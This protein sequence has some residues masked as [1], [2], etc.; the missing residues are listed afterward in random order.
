M[1]VSDVPPAPR[2]A[3]V[4]A[5]TNRPFFSVMVPSYNFTDYMQA[6]LESVL[7]QDPG[8]ST[9]Q[10]EVID[11][12]STSPG[13]ER[14]TRE[15]GGGRIPLHRQP[16]N[17]GQVGNFN[18]CVARAHGEWV[19]ILHCDDIVR[20]G[21][22]DRARQAALAHPEIGAWI[23]R[24]IYM[25][26]N[27]M[28]TGFS[29]PEEMQPGVLGPDFTLR[30]FL[31]QRMYFVSTLIRRST[32]E[33]LGGFRAELTISFDWDMWKRVAAQV[34]VYY[35]PEPLACFRIHSRSVYA[36][37]MRAGETVA[38]ERRSIRLSC[39]LDVPAENAAGLRRRAMRAA[40]IRAVRSARRQWRA[41]EHEIAWRLLL[42]AL[43]C[44]T[45]PSV[46]ARVAWAI[47]SIA[48]WTAEELRHPA[49]K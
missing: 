3:P 34:P 29:E 37:A 36:N 19:H 8:P 9:L 13:P 10:F 48:A 49:L 16:C 1:K 28:W 25:D 30:Q 43:K 11:D 5:G 24:V 26:E 45:A 23:C 20:P 22:Y 21:F 38:E 40:A 18:D 4:P 2:I 33:R 32:Y 12:C 41:G 15:V 14:V 6:T 47:E 46:L 31:E 39:A 44:S 35:D 17:L 42:E 27:G 7:S